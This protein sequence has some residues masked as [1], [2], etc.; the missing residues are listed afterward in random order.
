M[1]RLLECSHMHLT[2]T[3]PLTRPITSSMPAYQMDYYPR[4]KQSTPSISFMSS[5]YTHPIKHCSDTLTFECSKNQ[6]R[7]LQCNAEMGS[8]CFFFNQ[9]A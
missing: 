9:Y 6:R 2:L 8:L 7:Y 3:L 4:P 5:F 1:F